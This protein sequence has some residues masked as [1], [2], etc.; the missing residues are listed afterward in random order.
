MKTTNQFQKKTIIIIMIVIAI[1]QKKFRGAHWKSCQILP[2][3]K[4]NY[5]SY[6]KKEK[7]RKKDHK[8]GTV[9]IQ[10]VLQL[11][12]NRILQQLDPKIMR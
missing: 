11:I 6:W 2:H 10:Y 8:E 7:K 3:T 1:G 9:I 4:P 5:T 12:L